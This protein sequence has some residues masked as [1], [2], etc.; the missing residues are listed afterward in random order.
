[1]SA[2]LSVCPP[3]SASTVM[4]SATGTRAASSASARV[5]SPRST[6]G[7]SSSGGAGCMNRRATSGRDSLAKMWRRRTI[8]PAASIVSPLAAQRTTAG[9]SAMNADAEIDRTLRRISRSA[10][11]SSSSGSPGE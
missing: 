8:R 4:S 2:W 1:V 6:S 5:S 11:R 9:V 10:T 7:P 3:E